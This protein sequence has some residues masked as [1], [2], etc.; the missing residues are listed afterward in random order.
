MVTM[1]TVRL[2]A[3]RMY[4]DFK[5]WLSYWILIFNHLSRKQ[6]ILCVLNQLRAN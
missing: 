2:T 3:Y 1:Q 4:K 6:L 5:H